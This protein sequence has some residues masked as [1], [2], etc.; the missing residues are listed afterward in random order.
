MDV[1]ELI[2]DIQEVKHMDDVLNFKITLKHLII[3]GMFAGITVLLIY[4]IVVGDI[5]KGIEH[6]RFLIEYVMKNIVIKKIDETPEKNI[7]T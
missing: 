4:F 1:N 3:I 6:A 5:Q 2:N 7:D